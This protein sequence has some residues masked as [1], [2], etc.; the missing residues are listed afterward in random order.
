MPC[1]F[2]ISEFRTHIA[3]AVTAAFERGGPSAPVSAIMA[4]ISH[5][6][7]ELAE[8]GSGEE[9]ALVA[10]RA[11]CGFC[12]RVN[13]SVLWPEAFLI[14]DYI[15]RLPLQE[16]SSLEQKIAHTASR[17]RWMEDE[18]RIHCGITCPFLTAEQFCLIHPVRPLLCRSITS[19]D[20]EICRMAMEAVAAGEEEITVAM[21]LFQKFLMDTAFQSVAEALLALG[22]DDRSSELSAATIAALRHPTLTDDYMSGRRLE[23]SW[24]A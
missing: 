19:T 20:G 4:A 14:A 13:V 21:N 16:L 10:C 23:T 15:R 3:A 8:K 24:E 2:D 6:E 1:R 5:A 22:F 17:V 18:E 9:L 7:R 12:C 11:G